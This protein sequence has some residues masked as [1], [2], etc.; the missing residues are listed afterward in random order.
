MN[1]QQKVLELKKI[2]QDNLTPFITNDYILLDL[3]YFSNV[4]DVLIWQGT[5]DFLKTLPYKCLY[6]SSIE[7]FRQ[8]KIDGSIIILFMGGGN[9][10]DLWYR[11]QVFREKIL[12]AFPENR[13][14]QLPQSICFTDEEKLK[15]SVKVFSRHHKLTMCFR[16]KRSLDI[17][18]QYFPDS[19][20]LLV[21]DIAFCMDMTHWQKY[22]QKPIDRKIL[23]LDRKDCEKNAN[24]RYDIIPNEAENRDW[25]TMETTILGLTLFRKLQLILRKTDKISG[26][27]LNNIVSD[28]VYQKILRKYFI[29]SGISFLSNYST[30]YTTRLHV[31]ILS[32]LLDK[33]FTFFDNSYGKNKGVYEAWLNDI[34]SIQFIE[35]D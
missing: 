18:N 26:L 20:N 15:K 14:I 13:I 22:I 32:V 25:P 8:P 4:G 31:A 24:Q 28:A 2:I 10:G 27:K 19:T 3:P 34:D 17:A 23:Y 7:N 30:I 12:K 9:F 6:S 21:P 5:L 33:A 11:H 1:N 35:N 29:R 16:D